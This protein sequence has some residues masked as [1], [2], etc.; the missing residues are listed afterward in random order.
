MNARGFTILEALVAIVVA[1]AVCLALY[2]W[3]NSAIITLDKSRS[4]ML[5]SE[6]MIQAENLLATVNPMREPDGSVQF[7][8]GTV[9]WNAFPIE[10]P[11]DGFHPITGAY[12]DF[13]VALFE[14]DV[15][16]ELAETGETDQFVSRRA[17]WERT[18]FRDGF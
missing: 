4:A 2:A 13:R 18:R 7:V 10:G 6:L 5:K 9:S 8:L 1:S 17:G 11:G 3:M 15:T 14:I 12:S 16:L